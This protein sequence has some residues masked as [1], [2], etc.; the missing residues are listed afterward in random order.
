[1]IHSLYSP[2]VVNIQKIRWWQQKMGWSEE[3]GG[4]RSN[5]SS[6]GRRKCTHLWSGLGRVLWSHG[7]GVRKSIQDDSLLDGVLS[8]FYGNAMCHVC[9]IWYISGFFHLILLPHVGKSSFLKY[10][11]N[12]VI[13]LHEMEIFLQVL[14]CLSVIWNQ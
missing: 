2:W 4:Q 10:L 9:I 6:E 3:W 8:L 5:L 13:Y 1:M 7:E 11:K 12:W 14:E